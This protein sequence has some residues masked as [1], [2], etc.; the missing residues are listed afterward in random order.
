MH[1]IW[2]YVR[3]CPDLLCIPGWQQVFD[4][5]RIRWHCAVTPVVWK[6]CNCKS[7]QLDPSRN[8]L[9]WIRIRWHHHFLSCTVNIL[10]ACSVTNSRGTQGDWGYYWRCLNYR[11][12]QWKTY[13]YS[14]RWANSPKL[15]I[16][17]IVAVIDMLCS[18]MFNHHSDG[19]YV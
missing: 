8:F 3:I 1:A 2:C 4:V 16:T 13:R 17:Y 19:I 10:V 15:N 12:S 7:Q 5:D 9:I 6:K 11:R 18:I 14:D